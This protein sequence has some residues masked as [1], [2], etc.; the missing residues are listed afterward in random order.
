LLTLHRGMRYLWQHIISITGEYD[1]RLPLVHYLKHYCKQYPKLG[2]RDRRMLNTIIYSWY[3]GSKGLGAEHALP[4]ETAIKSCL[5]A[6]GVNMAEYERIFTDTQV[7]IIPVNTD[8]LFP[9]QAAL[10]DGITRADWLQSMLHQPDLFIRVRKNEKLIFRKLNDNNIHYSV[11]YPGCIQLP[12]GTAVDKLLPPDC[13]VV[14]D[15]SSQ[16]TGSLFHPAAGDRWYDCCSGAGGKS[17]LLID[18][19][20]QISLTVSDKRATILHNLGE[21]FRVYGHPQ[22]TAIVADASDKEDLVKKLGTQQFDYII[23]DVPCT[24]SGT[25]ARTP[26]QLFFFNPAA[27]GQFS[28]LQQQIATNVASFLKP[29]GSLVYITCSIFREEND[30]VINAISATTGL[31]IQE[32][33]LING[34]ARRS[35]SMFAAVLR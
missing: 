34:I 31:A 2:S 32:Q 24:G 11:V 35:D 20:V 8:L 14:Q 26:E 13:Y 25:W 23:C 9:G 3:R 15:A 22:P 30:T 7:P 27:I 21:R 19:G 18:K 1:G 29:G 5:A 10:S 17:L 6:C 12:N 33:R 28:T 4:T 16:E